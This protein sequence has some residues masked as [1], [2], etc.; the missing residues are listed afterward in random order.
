MS[1]KKKVLVA[2]LVAIVLVVAL[3]TAVVLAQD[4]PEPE[5]VPE[6]WMGGLGTEGLL[7]RMAE[8]LDIPQETLVA[9]FEQVW[10]EVR[11][12]RINQAT[13]D[14]ECICEECG[15]RF[16]ERKMNALQKREALGNKSFQ[17]ARVSQGARNRHMIAV[18]RGWQGSLSPRLVD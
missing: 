13:E 3:P 8:I 2:M 4:E 9:A 18:P 6:F 12:E 16:A 5:A 17:R 10:Q 14:N 7:A 1:E 15:E 11:E